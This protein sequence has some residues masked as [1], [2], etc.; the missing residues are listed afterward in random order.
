MGLLNL[1]K[2]ICRPKVNTNAI[3]QRL[4]RQALIRN[5]YGYGFVSTPELYDN[6]YLEI[7]FG[8][9]TSGYGDWGGGASYASTSPL[10][11]VIDKDYNIISSDTDSFYN[12]KESKVYEEI[13]MIIKKHLGPKL[14]VDTPILKES[15]D[16]IFKVIPV[17]SHI[18][19]D[20]HLDDI[21]HAKD[22]LK[23][24]TKQIE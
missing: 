15:I 14:V 20:I 18:G 2:K 10:K 3:F 4:G 7:G 16:R 12:S 13:A 6:S 23:Y 19:L 11:I 1:L 17:K 24:F 22:M 8:R 9:T 21:P 5:G